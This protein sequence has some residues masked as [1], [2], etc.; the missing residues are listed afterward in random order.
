MKQREVF[1]LCKS[2]DSLLAWTRSWS[3]GLQGELLSFTDAAAALRWM[4]SRRVDVLIASI[5]G[6]DCE[7]TLTVLRAIKRYRPHVRVACVS[8]EDH[9]S[10][11]RR[12]REAGA[13]LYLC[14]PDPEIAVQLLVKEVEPGHRPRARPPPKRYESEEKT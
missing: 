6:R 4:L 10:I 2:T 9:E 5:S 3:D 11:E 12:C 8:K 1:I 14:Q 7:E 13:D